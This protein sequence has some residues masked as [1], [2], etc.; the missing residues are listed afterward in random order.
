MK[1]ER[2][3]VIYM[4]TVNGRKYI[5][6]SVDFKVRKKYHLRNSEIGLDGAFYNAIRKHGVQAVV[7]DIIEGDIPED[8]LNERE[9]HW[10]SFYDTYNKG[11]NMTK[12]G[13][14][15]PMCNPEVAAKTSATKKSQASRGEL[16]T[17]RPEVRAKMSET[18][19]AQSARGELPTQCPKVREKISKSLKLLAT[20][21]ENPFQVHSLKIQRIKSNNRMEKRRE[22]GQEFFLDMEI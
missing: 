3:G 9:K 21:G 16:C 17:Q 15:S 1:K 6:Q 10:I 5:G 19:R 12:G 8:N 14:S 11:L 13:D 4:A 7:W 2:T 18:R 20:R 22:A